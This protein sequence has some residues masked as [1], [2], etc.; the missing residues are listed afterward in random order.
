MVAT[1]FFIAFTFAAGHQLVGLA[2]NK[3]VGYE[4]EDAQ[5]F[6]V[7]MSVFSFICLCSML[8]ISGVITS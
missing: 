3:Y 2:R 1:V 6:A 8:Y 7:L 4:V 5:I